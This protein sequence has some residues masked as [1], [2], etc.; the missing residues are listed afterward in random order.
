MKRLIEFPLENGDSILVEVDEA[1]EGTLVKAAL[2]SEVVAKAQQTFEQA[3][4][5]V[6]PASSAI[7]KKLR[8]LSDPPDEITVAFGL[9]LSAE[10]GAVVASAS[11]DANYTVTLKWKKKSSPEEKRAGNP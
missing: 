9:K 4:E 11:A 5:K 1:E 3:L 10:A 2:T 8:N 6:K 7:I